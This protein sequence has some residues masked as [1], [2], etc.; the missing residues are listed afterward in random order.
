MRPV[1]YPTDSTASSDPTRPCQRPCGLLLLT[2]LFLSFCFS[3]L[4]GYSIFEARDWRLPSLLLF[5]S[6][7]VLPLPVPPF[8]SPVSRLEP[9]EPRARRH[10]CKAIL[11]DRKSE[12]RFKHRGLAGR[13][14]KRVDRLFPF[15]LHIHDRHL[16][17]FLSLFLFFL[18]LRYV[19]LSLPLPRP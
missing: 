16:S 17:L 19:G 6:S 13:A 2:P 5:S 3:F 14:V 12:L 1:N 7:L 15:S 18:T 10:T 4:F 8:S 9:P 11:V